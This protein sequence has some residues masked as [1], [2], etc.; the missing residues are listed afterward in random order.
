[1]RSLSE[2]QESAQLLAGSDFPNAVLTSLLGKLTA[3]AGMVVNA[4]PYDGCLESCLLKWHEDNGMQLDYLS[5]S[6]AV[7]II[8]YVEKKIGFHLLQAWTQRNI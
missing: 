6:R 4:S 8:E 3:T 2:F 5:V 1:M 7:G